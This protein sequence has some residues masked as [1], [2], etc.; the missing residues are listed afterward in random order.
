MAALLFFLVPTACQKEDG[1]VRPETT[2]TFRFSAEID[3]ATRTTIQGRDLVWKT[4]DELT[5][6]WDDPAD[7]AYATG[8]ADPQTGRIEFEATLTAPKTQPLVFFH[9]YSPEGYISI[10]AAQQQPAPGVFEGRYDP[11]VSRN[12]AD[13]QISFDG[14]EYSLGSS[15]ELFSTASIILFRAV[16]SDP[17]I[18]KEVIQS[19]RF[20]TTDRT[21]LSGQNR[22]MIPSRLNHPDFPDG[23][24]FGSHL[25][26]SKTA[27]EVT[28]TRPE[29]VG[30]TANTERGI[31]LCVIPGQHQGKIT[32]R[33]DRDVYVF[34]MQQAIDFKR[35]H[36]KPLALNLKK[37]R[38]PSQN[39]RLMKSPEDLAVIH[40]PGLIS[41]TEVVITDLSMRRALGQSAAYASPRDNIPGT[42]PSVAISPTAEGELTPDEVAQSK[43]EVFTVGWDFGRD[44][45]G[46]SHSGY[47]FLADYDSPDKT[48]MICLSTAETSRYGVF[49][50]TV[51]FAFE[52][53]GVC[54]ANAVWHIAV[55]STGQTTVTAQGNALGHKN[56]LIF[57]KH[58]DT[59]TTDNGMSQSHNKHILIFYRIR[60]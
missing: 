22:D 27:A 25:T 15:V 11:L 51:P 46:R 45:Q 56:H 44:S 48:R 21:P 24:A 4:G 20:E 40:D 17:D 19:V 39:F 50:G 12:I 34:E 6:F 29:P 57:D 23:Y 32:V 3:P 9:P 53:D 5:F 16:S 31:Y 28:L 2:H 42:L 59:F 30:T 41:K 7:P 47:S 13:D 36:V 35:A 38:T 18:Q 1:P 37:A 43:A 33:T 52:S 14:T 26:A 49:K 55:Q 58:N 60:K 10:P 8:K 54:S